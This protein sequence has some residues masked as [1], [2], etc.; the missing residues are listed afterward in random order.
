MGTF[1]LVYGG[2]YGYIYEKTEIY[3]VIGGDIG[4]GI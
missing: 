4:R 2:I 3:Y 1:F